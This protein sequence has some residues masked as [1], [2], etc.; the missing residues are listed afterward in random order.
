RELQFLGGP[1]ESCA[2]FSLPAVG[3]V[4]RAARRCRVAADHALPR[5]AGLLDHF[6][7]I[8]VLG[9]AAARRGRDL[10]QVVGPSAQTLSQG[11]WAL[12]TLLSMLTALLLVLPVA[13]VYMVTKRRSGYDQSVVQ[14]VII[15]PMTVAG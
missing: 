5:P 15:L 9:I 12:V 10:E 8:S 4:L 1:R 3:G 2:E 7:D 14:T 11:E 6:R 13:W